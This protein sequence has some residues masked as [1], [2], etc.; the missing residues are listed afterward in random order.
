MIDNFIKFY[1]CY[2]NLHKK[3]KITIFLNYFTSFYELNSNKMTLK[4]HFN[5][6]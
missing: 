6:L 4:N 3:Y 1:I 5:Q 2:K